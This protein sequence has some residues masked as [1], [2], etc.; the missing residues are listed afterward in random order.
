MRKALL[1]TS[2]NSRKGKSPLRALAL[3]S[4]CSATALEG[5]L[6]VEELDFNHGI[7]FFHEMKYSA[8]ASHLEYLNPNAPK[9]GRL[10]EATQLNFNSISPG[11]DR[12]VQAPGAF[13]LALDTLIIRAGDEVSSFYGRLA[14]GIA[15]TNDQ[16]S[17][18]FRI[19]QNARWHDGTPI[20]SKD[21]AFTFN[22]RKSQVTGGL[23]FAFI[24]EVE[25]LDD[26][27]VAL[28]LAEPLTLN[29][30]IMVQFSPILPEHY[31]TVH[32]PMET[33]K[34]IPVGSGPYRIRS[35]EFGR[36]IEY[37]RV[38]DYWG[39][40]ILV[41]RGRYNFD[42]VRYDVYRDATIIREAF[43]KGLIDH[44]TEQDVRYWHSAYDIPAMEK[45]WIKK[46]R[47]NFGIEIGIRRAIA[48]NNRLEKFKDRRVRQALTLAMD[49]EWQ[50]RTLHF[51]Y[52]TRAHSYFP[53][54]ELAATELPSA[55]ELELLEPYKDQLPP[56]LF[57]QEFRFS[58][59]KSHEHHRDN[60]L[61]ARKLLI[62]AGW[63]LQDGK[64]VDKDGNSFEMEFL[65]QDQEDF[66]VLLPY[67]QQLKQL[68]IQAKVRFVDS[69]Q[70]NN[71]VRSFKFDALLKNS[72]V[73]LPPMIELMS[74]YHS[75]SVNE[76]LSR[77]TPGITHPVLDHLIEK[78]NSASTMPEIVAAC[79]AIDRV[80]LW[81][82]Y[83]IPLNA[84]DRPRTVH[85]DKFGRP[86]F[87][88]RYWP[89]FPDGWWWDDEKA[90]RIKLEQ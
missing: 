54:T 89:A 67:F 64:L 57:L 66:R 13:W 46:I 31:W 17:L 41:N 11:D 2:T 7:S 61:K 90:A 81:G 87:E 25:V 83:T 23:W 70:F 59:V 77:N 32:D 50:N 29:H 62:D 26:R 16:M 3:F 19:H 12:G 44:W 76:P 28:H 58:E 85:W 78:A 14:D 47:R 86:E 43:R 84:V 79:R 20:T 24:K 52:H 15:V 80:L 65:S 63:K 82:F 36:F 45:G 5:E 38:E 6:N 34:E 51:G 27:H 9:G 48:F 4:V 68:G 71:R 22:F 75:S 49:F 33:T 39:R 21:V 72:D 69:S 73:L 10:V 60:M 42:T 35:V 40:D 88:S 1:G 8:D 37:E 18:V 55:D 56:E 74:T 53:D 30:V